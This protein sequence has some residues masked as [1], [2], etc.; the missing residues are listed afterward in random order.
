MF[1]FFN[2]FK[3]KKDP[4]LAL[5][6]QAL[7]ANYVFYYKLK[8]REEPIDTRVLMQARTEK[9][10]DF[11]FFYKE[12]EKILAKQRRKHVLPLALGRKK[13]GTIHI[14]DLAAQPHILV[15][16]KTGSGKSTGL[17]N[18]IFSLLKFCHPSFLDI[19]LIDAKEGITFEKYATIAE[20]ATTEE[21]IHKALDSAINAMAKRYLKL[22]QHGFE[23]AADYNK[24]AFK[25]NT[26]PIKHKVLVF[27]EF[28]DFSFQDSEGMKKLIRLAQKGRAAGIHLILA[29]QRPD[30]DVI[31]GL[32]KANFSSRAV[33]QTIN[34][35][36]STVALDFAGA[37]ELE[38]Q[39]EFIWRGNLGI[40]IL[41][42]PSI[43]TDSIKNA[44]KILAKK[45]RIYK[46]IESISS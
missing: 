8:S 24:H 22:K 1:N 23:K 42:T 45:E 40:F 38:Q 31:S 7:E 30:K 33:Y 41:E 26:R 6:E 5:W 43:C 27:D 9:N 28:A 32:I 3:K 12:A 11:F 4:I 21:E 46:Y 20:I 18:M 13:D 19:V 10:S 35:V 44:I 39:G 16:G 36:N 15:A 29:T 17:H 25:H 14:E 34:R 2:P 37:E